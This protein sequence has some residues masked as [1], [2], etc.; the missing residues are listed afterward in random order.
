MY[1]FFVASSL[2]VALAGC[3]GAPPTVPPSPAPV[4]STAASAFGGTDRSWIEINLAM[5]EE[6]LPLLDLVQ[7][8]SAL[9]EVSMQ[10]RAF[11][12]TELA[13]L[14]QLHTEA[15]LPAEN[16]HKGMPMPGMVM[17]SHVSA[18][19]ALHGKEFDA[20]LREHLRAHLEQGRMLA[21]SERTA[22]LEPRTVALATRISQARQ[23]ALSEL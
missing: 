7:S 9:H 18:A 12:E 16:P 4:I 14:R 3:A 2:T 8:N 10:V 13:E 15:G 6:L 17:P 23:A 22:G 5:N 19:A 20:K 21:E 11:T 1:R